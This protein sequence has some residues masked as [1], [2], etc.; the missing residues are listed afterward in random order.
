[1]LKWLEPILDDAYTEEIDKKISEE[2]GKGFVARADFNEVS[3]AKKQLEKDVAARDAQLESL[4]AENGD[5]AA[6]RTQIE[7]L[8]KQNAASKADYEA[9]LAQVRI[10]AAVEAACMA[11]GA[12]NNT[13]VKALL[14]DFLKNAK[15]ADDGTVEGLENE[16][17]DM[18]KAEGTAFLFESGNGSAQFRGMTPGNPG[19][20]TP[21]AEK[22]LSEMSYGEIC[23]YLDAHPD[24][25]L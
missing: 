15:L 5:A 8:Q 9:Q 24:A 20:N 22:K 6:L 14:A 18:A 11:A 10:D 21:P 19:G 1:M 13:A 7:D 2:I 4:K 25:K 17:A 3:A 23:A 16:L 12:K